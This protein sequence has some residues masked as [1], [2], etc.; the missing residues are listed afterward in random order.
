MKPENMI[1]RQTYNVGFF[2]V[3][4][5]QRVSIDGALGD[6]D[7]SGQISCFADSNLKELFSVRAACHVGH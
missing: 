3:P 1:G 7:L 5:K 4:A 2:A 6:W